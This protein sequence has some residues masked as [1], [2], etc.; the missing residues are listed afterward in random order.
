MK[1]VIIPIECRVVSS[2]ECP[3]CKVIALFKMEFGYMCEACLASFD[4]NKKTNLTY[5]K[6]TI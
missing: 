2:K 4:E 5:D 6:K 1:T 3:K